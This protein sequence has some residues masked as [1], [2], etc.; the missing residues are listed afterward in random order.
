MS[1]LNILLIVHVAICVFLI[2][3]ILLQQGKGADVGAT[4]GGGGNTLFGAAGA[5]NL[6]TRVTAFAAG[7][8]MITS[9]F[10]AVGQKPGLVKGG[11]IFEGLPSQAPAPEAKVVQ[12]SSNAKSDLETGKTEVESSQA[13]SV[14]TQPT[15]VT[16]DLPENAKVENS[17]NEKT[18]GKPQVDTKSSGQQ[19]KIIPNSNSGETGKIV[20]GEGSIPNPVSVVKENISPVAKDLG[21]SSK[22]VSTKVVEALTNAVEEGAASSN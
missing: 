18:L 6:L 3:I 14:Q 2:A 19:S 20:V 8:F 21:S 4:F 10:L 15:A 9:I 13:P 11:T 7:G 12:P 22:A 17:V 16:G 1:Y 5:D